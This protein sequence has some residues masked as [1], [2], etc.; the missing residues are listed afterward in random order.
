MGNKEKPCQLCEKIDKSVNQSHSKCLH[1]SKCWDSKLYRPSNCEDCRRLFSQSCNTD[2]SEEAKQATA[3]A[4]LMVEAWIKRLIKNRS[5]SKNL[6]EGVT[7]EDLWFDAYEKA[8]FDPFWSTH[9]TTALRVG[10]KIQRKDSRSGSVTP[11][12]PQDIVALA[13]QD[14]FPVLDLEER[15]NK[16]KE[17]IMKSLDE[18]ISLMGASIVENISAKFRSSEPGPSGVQVSKIC[19]IPVSFCEFV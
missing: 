9:W 2:Q 1:C 11:N 8:T 5:Q 6:G 17:D 13:A 4:R 19:D 7:P 10:K 14:N 16:L 3:Q 18:K 12:P 15:D